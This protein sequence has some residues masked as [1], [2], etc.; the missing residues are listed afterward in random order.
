MDDDRTRDLEP[1]TAAIF[2]TLHSGPGAE[3]VSTFEDLECEH[4]DDADVWREWRTIEA[5]LGALP[6]NV[7]SGLLGLLQER[8]Q[9]KRLVKVR[10][11]IKAA[12]IAKRRGHID[13]AQDYLLHA[14]I[15]TA[16][17]LQD[18]GADADDVIECEPLFLDWQP[19]RE[20]VRR[21]LLRNAPP[22]TML[23][24]SAPPQI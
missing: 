12:G 21:A 24:A 18:S 22:V 1:L 7:V 17:E 2:N 11:L 8:Q 5:A 16:K 13:L 4:P 14:L 23:L 20:E 3:D 15:T 19:T 9:S 10:T 6:S